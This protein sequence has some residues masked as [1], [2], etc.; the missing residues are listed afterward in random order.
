M[1]QELGRLPDAELEIMQVLW[2]LERYPAYTDE[3]AAGLNRDWKAPTLLKLLSRLEKRGFVREEKQGH[4]NG[5]TP[6]VE[7]QAYLQ[8]EGRSFLQRLC[9]GSMG[10]LIASL[11][12][13]VQ[14][15][16]EDLEALEAILHKEGK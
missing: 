12:P 14:L 11:Y 9:G 13:Q 10:K 1:E 5:Y 6:L 16:Q 8:V 4:R 3:I 15:T 2:S 7:E